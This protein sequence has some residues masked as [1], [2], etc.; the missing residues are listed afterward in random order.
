MVAIVRLCLYIVYNNTKLTWNVENWRLRT[1]ENVHRFR[2]VLLSFMD[3]FMWL[4]VCQTIAWISALSFPYTPTLYPGTRST[5][6][7]HAGSCIQY[8]FKLSVAVRTGLYTSL[9]KDCNTFEARSLYLSR[10]TLTRING[11]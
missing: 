6:Y 3:V 4:H 5:Y 8:T 10:H 11:S 9:Q 2:I 1:F 7:L